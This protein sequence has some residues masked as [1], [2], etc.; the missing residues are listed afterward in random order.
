MLNKDQNEKNTV[1][2]L[3]A[4]EIADALGLKLEI[5]FI[6]PETGEKI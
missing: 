1:R 3:S 4:E 5:S 2:Q 6:D